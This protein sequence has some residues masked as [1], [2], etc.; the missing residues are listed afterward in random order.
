MDA[1]DKKRVCLFCGKELQPSQYHNP[2]GKIDERKKFCNHLC[3]SRYNA[4]KQYELMKSDE[5]YR[6]MAREKSK[7]WYKGNRKRQNKNLLRYYYFNKDKWNERT[8][9]HHNKENI[10]LF[11]N[12]SCSQCG[13]PT[14]LFFHRAYGNYP[15]LRKGAGNPQ[16]RLKLI[17]EYVKNN[18]IGVCSLVCLHKL[19]QKQ[20]RYLQDALGMVRL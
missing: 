9:C 13:K 4:R 10:K 19:K 5:G 12:P 8:F 6:E 7:Q 17:E 3:G 1:A 14:K 2:S 15:K 18:L 20:Q 16:E 11:I